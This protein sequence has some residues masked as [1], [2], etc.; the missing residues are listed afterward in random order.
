MAHLKRINLGLWQK[1]LHKNK[2]SIMRILFPHSKM[3][4]HMDIR[5]PRNS[6]SWKFHQMDVKSAFLNGYMKENVFVSQPKG[7]FVKG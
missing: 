1:V 4:Y 5:C 3:G 7:F 2:G 6:K